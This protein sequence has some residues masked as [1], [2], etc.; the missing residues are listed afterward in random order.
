MNSNPHGQYTDTAPTAAGFDIRRVTRKRSEHR[1]SH[2]DDM[3]GIL[4]HLRG[5][6]P[7][8]AAA[9]LGILPPI[10]NFAVH[11][12]AASA[13]V[14]APGGGQGQGGTLPDGGALTH[15][16]VRHCCLIPHCCC[17]QAD[18]LRSLLN[19][20]LTTH[21]L[22]LLLKPKG[23][24]FMLAHWLHSMSICS[25]NL[26]KRMSGM[27][28]CHMFWWLSHAGSLWC[29]HGLLAVSGCCKTHVHVCMFC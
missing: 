29:E 14:P 1:R 3:S 13:G 4:A 27:R 21:G 18:A 2:R 17:L 25:L 6:A 16:P 12:P 5:S 22:E 15:Q 23:S 10:P 28:G 9:Q 26:Q 8:A 19:C 20:L 7:T 24:L 11:P